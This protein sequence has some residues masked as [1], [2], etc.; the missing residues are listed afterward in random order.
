MTELNQ[1]RTRVIEPTRIK[2]FSSRT[3][4]RFCFELRMSVNE[5][6]S[7]WSRPGLSMRMGPRSSSSLILDFVALAARE[8]IGGNHAQN[9]SETKYD[10]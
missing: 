10:S 7:L 9:K 8:H 2:A 3:G 1:K 6:T 5:A 4:R